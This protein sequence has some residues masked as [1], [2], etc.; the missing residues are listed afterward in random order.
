MEKNDFKKNNL[1]EFFMHEA[2]KLAELGK[3]FTSPN[4]LVGCVIV[5]ENKIIGRG[6]HHKFGNPH[7]EIEAINNAF[8]LGN[9][10]EGACLYVNLEPCSHYGK[11]PPCA[12][13]LVK[14]KISRVVI[15]MRDPNELVNGKGI[16]ILRNANIQVIESCLEN[17]AKWLNRGFIRVHTLKRPYVTLKAASSLDGKL[18]L[19]NGSSKWITNEEAR[20]AAHAL[21]AENDAVLVGIGT[22]LTDNPEL[23]VR[24]V[25]GNNPKRIIL[26][27]DLRTPLDAKILN[28][29]GKCVIFCGE[30]ANQEKIKSLE[31]SGAKIIKA[32]YENNN[33][34]L[35]FVLEYLALNEGILNLMVEG[36][37]KILNSFIRENLADY[38]KIFFAPKILGEGISFGTGMNFDSVSD[39]PILIDVKSQM[40]NQNI[41]L[42]GR[43]Q[44]S[45]DL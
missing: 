6:Y 19:K 27:K 15:G 32:N 39:A 8:S 43:F 28:S 37:A 29:D 34:S 9:K 3:G 12:E 21:R 33:I 14:E 38:M 30:N 22:V 44:C 23:T 17:D 31:N 41:L 11:T 20:I 13:R 4:P 5:K 25:K 18:A 10:I 45:P 1:D 16:N 42:E 2:L 35:R 26:D 40:L 7:A 36:G 24:H